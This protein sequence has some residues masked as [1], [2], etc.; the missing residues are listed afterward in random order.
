MAIREVKSEWSPE[1]LDYVKSFLCHYESDVAELPECCVGSN[2][3]V[4]E[5][6]SEYVVSSSGKW[7][8]R[9]K[10][11]EEGGMLGGSTSKYAQPD[12]GAETGL[13][14]ILPET[15]LTVVGDSG[16][17]IIMQEVALTVGD[18]Y[19][20]SYNGADYACT[21]F[22]VEGAGTVLGNIGAM[23][24]SI[25]ATGEPFFAS[26]IPEEYRDQ[27]GGGSM[28]VAPLD[29]N[30]TFT[31]AINGMGETVHPIPG[32]Y[33]EAAREPLIVTVSD[34]TGKCDTDFNEMLAAARSGRTVLLRYIGAIHTMS[35]ADGARITFTFNHN[36]GPGTQ[37]YCNF[38]TIESDNTVHFDQYELGMP[39]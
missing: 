30:T 15:E 7:V 23:D 14:D 38:Y 5:T 25:P 6:N 27:Y 19:T 9:G 10:A 33:L 21:A 35:G 39:I 2:A 22:F 16:M 18:T 1:Q 37:G 8:T 26:V 36:S 13:I 32:K 34:D 3:K 20:V 29:G 24:E 28:I 17:A 11:I 31:L 4:S 12:W